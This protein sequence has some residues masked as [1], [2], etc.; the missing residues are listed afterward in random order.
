MPCEISLSAD[1]KYVIMK[2][3][4]D[5]TRKS[6]VTWNTE[7][8]ALGRK[9]G[10]NRFL[11]DLTESV[12]VESPSRNYEFANRDMKTP[13]GIDRFARVVLVVSPNDHS[14][15]F[16]ETVARNAGLNVTIFRDRDKALQFLLED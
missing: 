5:M 15:D 6:A 4:G 7:A 1:Q 13:P 16:V 10:V 8:H 12:N 11:V 2:V 14:H 9:A 3:V